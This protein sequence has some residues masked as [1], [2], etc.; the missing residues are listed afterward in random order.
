[1]NDDVENILYRH[2][3]PSPAAVGKTLGYSGRYVKELCR[4]LGLPMRDAALPGST[5][6]R[7]RIPIA[8]FRALRRHVQGEQLRAS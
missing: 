6:H 5:Q 8:T 3:E 2:R 7:W 1:M 4:K